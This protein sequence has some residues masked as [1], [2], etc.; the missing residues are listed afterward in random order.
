MVY[1]YFPEN[2]IYFGSYSGIRDL[3][4]EN[5]PTKYKLLQYVPSYEIILEEGDV[6]FNPGPW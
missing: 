5:I 4:D 1:P 6:L 3:T 2:G